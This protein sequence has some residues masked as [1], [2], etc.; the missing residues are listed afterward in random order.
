VANSG[1]I[2]DDAG[3]R[4]W[5]LQCTSSWQTERVEFSI[6]DP[7]SPDDETKLRWYLEKYP[8]KDPF[9]VTEAQQASD[10]LSRYGVDLREQ[11]QLGDL[12]IL[13]K[14]RGE[15]DPRKN[16]LEIKIVDLASPESPGDTVHRLHWELLEDPA[17]WP[18]L[19]LLAT[20][21]RITSV[22]LEA[23]SALGSVRSWP[24]KKT[25][26]KATFNVLLIVARD[27]AEDQISTRRWNPVWLP[28]FSYM[29]ARKSR[30]SE[31]I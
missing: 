7:W 1:A 29:S 22:D 24:P 16:P 27:L 9:A 8:R 15:K 28:T 6:R 4:C 13:E 23:I 30:R 26:G 20:V 12:S 5:V 19:D 18:G 31:R 11:L 3:G 25:I 2:F 21:R 10:A 14:A 17:L